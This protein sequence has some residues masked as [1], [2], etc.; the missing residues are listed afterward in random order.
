MAD[1]AKR[2]LI[3]DE[4]QHIRDILKTHF[5]TKGFETITCDD[6]ENALHLIY[7][8]HPDLIILD[9]DIQ[10]KNGYQVCR[11]IK[12]EKAYREVF[13]ILLSSKEQK[14]EEFWAKDCG[15]NKFLI[16]PFITSE[17]EEIVQ[18][19]FEA[20]KERDVKKKISID[21]EIENKKKKKRSYGLCSFELQPKSS[22]LFEQKYGEIRYSE[23]L[24]KVIDAI[25]RYGRKFDENMILEQEDENK[26][27]LLLEGKRKDIQAKAGELT[28]RIND[29]LKDLHDEEDYKKGFIRRN[30]QTDQ[31]EKA[32]P[33]AIQM[34]LSFSKNK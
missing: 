18:E 15:A 21:E 17:L 12:S 4:S 23:M 27:I 14:E 34:K 2:I 6:G 13:V 29:L 9:I 30:V 19:Y 7:E 26:F 22:N 16:K 10:R 28:K 20:E 33:L 32:P 5:E 31:V 25:E 24:D 1:S 8:K 11:Q 3:A